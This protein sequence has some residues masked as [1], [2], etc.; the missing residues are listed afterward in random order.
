[1]IISSQAGNPVNG[2]E[3]ILGGGGAY[4]LAAKMQKDFGLDRTV[5]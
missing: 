3:V 1:M 4:G 5:N 2:S